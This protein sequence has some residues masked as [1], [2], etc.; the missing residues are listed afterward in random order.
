MECSINQFS[1]KFSQ[2]N[3]VITLTRVCIKK[4]QY[5]EVFLIEIKLL[6]EKKYRFSLQRLVITHQKYQK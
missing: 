4:Q 3:L 2:F 5:S 1:F 6:S